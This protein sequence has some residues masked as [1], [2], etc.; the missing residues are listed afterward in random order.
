MIPHGDIYLSWQDSIL[1]IK[2]VGPF[3]VE[4]ATICFEQLQEY[5][6]N[7]AQGC[8]KRIDYAND[9]TLGEPE[10]MVVFGKSYLWSFEHGCQAMALVYSNVIQ[11]IMCE[12]FVSHHNLNI[13][14]FKCKKN[15]LKWLEQM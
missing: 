10:A 1:N 15:A 3:N 4:G 14:L 13:K 7:N 8:W 2:T 12:Q 5:V 6:N 9:D 11:K